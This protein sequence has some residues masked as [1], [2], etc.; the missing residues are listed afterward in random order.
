MANEALVLLGRLSH[1]QI[2]DIPVP[3]GRQ[4][5]ATCYLQVQ[6]LTQGPRESLANQQPILSAFHL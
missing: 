6:A 3:E 2:R 4:Q 1:S 5:S